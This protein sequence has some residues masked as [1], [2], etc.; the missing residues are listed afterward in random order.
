MGKKNE[1]GVAVKKE[2][3]SR[4]AGEGDEGLLVDYGGRGR[5]DRSKEE[6]NDEEACL[7]DPLGP[8]ISPRA[9]TCGEQSRC[10]R[11]PTQLQI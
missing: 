8:L 6:E 1:V 10:Q 5:D 3:G 7:A 11:V 4:S 2:E 9:T